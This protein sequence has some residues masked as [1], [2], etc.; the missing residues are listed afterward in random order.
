MG[1]AAFVGGPGG[2]RLEH[3][4]YGCILDDTC[5]L[6]H[7]LPVPLNARTGE[8]EALIQAT[9]WS[10]THLGY[11][12]VELYYDA[13]SVGHAGTGQ[14]NFPKDDK[15]AKTL[16]ALIQ[17]A[18]MYHDRGLT[19][20]H[21]KAH[22]GILGNEVANFLA[23][24]ARTVQTTE[25]T[26]KIDLGRYVI[27]E[28]MP[29]EWLWMRLVP[30]NMLEEAYPHL[31]Q[32]HIEAK[33]PEIDTDASSAFPA[34]LQ[35]NSP[36]V[37]KLVY[38]NFFV[39]TYNVG[40]LQRVRGQPANEG[41]CPQ[42]YL[43]RQAQAHGITCLML[44]E[45]RARNTGM[46]ISDTHIRL[47]AACDQGKGGTE[48]WLAKRSSTG[49]KLG[50]NK[51]DILVLISEPELLCVRVRW[52]FGHYLLVSAHSPHSG[53][54]IEAITDWWTWLSETLTRLHRPEHEWLVI[55]IDANTNFETDSH[56]HIGTYG[57]VQRENV[58][59]RHF[60]ALLHRHELYLPSTFEEQH[61]GGYDTWRVAF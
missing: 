51:E 19:G 42:E 61:S 21:V 16:R 14:W 28:R 56:P 46:V 31:A 57:L 18:E 26:S 34:Q 4:A 48:I 23:Q 2:F 13:I 53:S 5:P 30:Y 50:I 25:G 37:T 32:G 33:G 35:E 44:Q 10:L 27:G 55:G 24:F 36:Q 59:A 7:G 22:T 52:Q 60:R 1:F 6:V 17:Y 58:V 12:P 47:V 41:L 43:R 49:R 20:H 39:A 3:M 40:S 45:T 8:I 11:Y 9:I 38:A 54:G 29:I 15:H